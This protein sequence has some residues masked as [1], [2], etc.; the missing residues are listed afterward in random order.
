MT[1]TTGVAEHY[2][3]GGLLDR[4]KAG[5]K[6][7]G[8]SEPIDIETLAP[9]D[10]FHMGGRSATVPFVDKMGLT[11]DSRVLDLGCGVGGPARYTAKTTGAH[12]TGI[13]L[14]DEFVETGNEL[15]G[16][17]GLTDRVDLV[18]GSILELPF[19]D[20]SFD[21][22]YM[23][24]VGMNIADKATLMAE[25][26]RALKPGGLFAIYDVMLVGDGDLL[27]PVPWAS[28]S[29]GSAL[30]SPEQYRAAL[31]EAGFEIVSEIDRTS[32]AEDFFAAQAAAQATVS[33]PPALGLHLV[34][35][36]D[37][38]TIIGN[39]VANLKQ[40]RIAPV[41]IIARLKQ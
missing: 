29:K 31:V 9:V 2:T 8:A 12:V 40:G 34:I 15:S 20:A 26:A 23:I 21:V 5:L 32:F 37:V 16:M 10:E 13:D 38:K 1:E 22:A 24:H 18:Q 25:T 4:I 28:D 6:E 33:G 3:K 39:M 17:T 7:L 41:E 11:P 36:S 35:G 27:L 19:A 14:T 30:A